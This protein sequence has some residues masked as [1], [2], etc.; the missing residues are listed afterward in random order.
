M[1]PDGVLI[2]RMCRHARIGSR[3]TQDFTQAVSGDPWLSADL[4]DPDKMRE[5]KKQTGKRQRTGYQHIAPP[6]AVHREWHAAPP[7]NMH[8]AAGA[9]PCSP[10]AV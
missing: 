9:G 1:L 6:Q 5:R 4:H 2:H 7:Q 8:P 10:A 3:F